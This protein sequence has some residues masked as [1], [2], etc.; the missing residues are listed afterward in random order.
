[1]INLIHSSQYSR[2]VSML[3]ITK[4]LY[5]VSIHSGLGSVQFKGGCYDIIGLPGNTLS[6]MTG[7]PLVSCH[8]TLSISW[9]HLFLHRC[10]VSNYRKFHSICLYIHTHTHT[11]SLFRKYR[12]LYRPAK[13]LAKWELT[14]SFPIIWRLARM[15]TNKVFFSWIHNSSNKM[16]TQIKYNSIFIFSL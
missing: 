11:T 8:S 3:F 1:M 4:C 5:T 12:F 6:L 7:F 13:C 9:P 14:Q 15:Q 2:L 10:I 16:S